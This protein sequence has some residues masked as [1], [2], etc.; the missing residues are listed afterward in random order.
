MREIK[1]NPGGVA[2][3]AAILLGHHAQRRAEQD[4][5]GSAV[6]QALKIANH[7]AEQLRQ[8]KAEYDAKYSPAVTTLTRND[9]GSFG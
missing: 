7:G 3:A 8:V 5:G 4:P 1:Q 9:D 2:A 6:A